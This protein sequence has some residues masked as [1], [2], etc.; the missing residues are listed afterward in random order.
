VT[1]F[2]EH[3][4][5]HLDLDS[6]CYR[7]LHSI[8]IQ[9][10]LFSDL[11]E[12]CVVVDDCLLLDELLV[13]VQEHVLVVRKRPP[14]PQWY[15]LVH[16]TGFVVRLAF[17]ILHSPAPAAALPAPLKVAGSGSFDFA[18]SVVIE[19]IAGAVAP[20]VPR[21]LGTG[22]VRPYLIPGVFWCHLIP[23]FFLLLS[24]S[25]FAVLIMHHVAFS[26]S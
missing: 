10:G 23:L 21:A 2:T 16:L 25:F 20:A 1:I 7:L 18:V 4:H 13:V 5:R 14:D 3:F 17:N 8:I 11:P 12:V 6:L 15:F 24:V 9:F 22:V 19:R 26:C